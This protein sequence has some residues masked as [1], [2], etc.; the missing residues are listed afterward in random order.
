M[1]PGGTSDEQRRYE[2]E[3]AYWWK[4]TGGDRHKIAEV[5]K[6]IEKRRGQAGM[7]KVRAGLME[8]WRAENGK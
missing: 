2:C 3:I 4:A 6:R 5:L 7:E 8:R 1:K